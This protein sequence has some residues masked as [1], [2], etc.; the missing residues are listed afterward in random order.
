MTVKQKEKTNA[1]PQPARRSAI[2]IAIGEKVRQTLGAPPEL[3]RVQVR[4][5]WDAMF[6][7]NVF[8]GETASMKIAH[9]YFLSTDGEGNILTSSPSIVKSY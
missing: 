9:S 1:E 5:L 3:N 2:D 7:V 4:P 6:R 8:T